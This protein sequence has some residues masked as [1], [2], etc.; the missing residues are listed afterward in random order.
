M[1]TARVTTELRTYLCIII[2]TPIPTVCTWKTFGII[3]MRAVLNVW[4]VYMYIR[5]IYEPA[6]MRLSLIFLF[7][8]FFLIVYI[9]YKTEYI[10][11]RTRT[12]FEKS[13]PTRQVD[14]RSVYNIIYIGIYTRRELTIPNAISFS[15]SGG[16]AFA[17][18]CIQYNRIHAYTQKN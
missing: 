11:S 8:F 2:Y 7:L 15:P 3:I 14:R 1:K 9:R 4:Y 6:M 10:N 18:I 17:D 16:G 5:Y 12:K 13:I